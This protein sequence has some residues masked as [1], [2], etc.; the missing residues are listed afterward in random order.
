LG[1]PDGDG[2]ASTAGLGET[3]PEAL[4]AF[5]GQSTH[6]LKRGG[7]GRL[8]AGSDPVRL[9]S[10]FARRRRDESPLL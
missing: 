3:K 9:A 1:K 5:I 7:Q 2:T 8:P 6:L 4:G 10:I